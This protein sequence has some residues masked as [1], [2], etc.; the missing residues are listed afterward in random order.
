M[1]DEIEQLRAELAVERAERKKGEAGLLDLSRGVRAEIAMNAQIAASRQ[2]F[3][4]Q[5][6]LA[7]ITLSLSTLV[8]RLDAHHR[9]K[10]Q[11][12]LQVAEEILPADTSP[13]FRKQFQR[14]AEGLFP[15]I[16]GDR[17]PP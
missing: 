13:E 3:A 9:T 2:D 4:M 7:V 10:L 6:Q 1:N 16:W 11:A 5:G 12:A 15:G 8:A 17:S 14:A